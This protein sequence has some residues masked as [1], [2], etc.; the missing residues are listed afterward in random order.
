[1][2]VLRLTSVFLRVRAVPFSLAIPPPSCCSRATPLHSA[3]LRFVWFCRRRRKRWVSAARAAETRAWWRSANGWRKCPRGA[4]WSASAPR[5]VCLRL[6]PCRHLPMPPPP[7]SPY[8]FLFHHTHTSICCNVSAPLVAQVLTAVE[9]LLEGGAAP[10]QASVEIALG[11]LTREGGD[12]PSVWL[13]EAA[14]W[15]SR[16][17]AILSNP[18]GSGGGGGPTAS[19]TASRPRFEF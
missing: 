14:T 6:L 11:K 17:R 18:S 13:H 7:P 2:R 3:P 5:C 8:P 15:E 12:S 16:L 1:M 4:K 19:A 10:R 9:S